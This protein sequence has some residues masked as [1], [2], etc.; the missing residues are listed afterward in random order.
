MRLFYNQVYRYTVVI[1]RQREQQLPSLIELWMVYGV[2]PPLYKVNLIQFALIYK[3]MNWFYRR[4]E[5]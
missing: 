2:H 1:T 4:E 3:S 5:K